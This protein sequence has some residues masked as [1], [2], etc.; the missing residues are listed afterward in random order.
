MANKLTQ[1]LV[2]ILIPAHNEALVIKQTL[3][4]VLQLVSAKD[5]FVVR[6]K[7]PKNIPKMSYLFILML[8][9][10]VRQTPQLPILI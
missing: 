6:P 10:P 8:E 9:K 4:S 1:N 3:L 7:L 5:I 2:A